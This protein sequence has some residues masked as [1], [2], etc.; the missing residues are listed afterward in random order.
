MWPNYTKIRPFKNSAFQLAI[1]EKK[2]V[3]NYAD[4]ELDRLINEVFNRLSEDKQIQALDYLAFLA[5][6]D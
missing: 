2:E 1:E 4:A 6:Q 3:S 5:S